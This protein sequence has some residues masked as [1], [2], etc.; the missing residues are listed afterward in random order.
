VSA[1]SPQ[2]TET[3]SLWMALTFMFDVAKWQNPFWPKYPSHPTT[4]LV[5]FEMLLVVEDH[6]YQPSSAVIGWLSIAL[7]WI[8]N[9]KLVVL[10]VCG[11][12]A[13]D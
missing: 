7:T 12:D 2:A 6:N 5:K 3:D 13:V 8:S 4:S 10:R 11:Q 1:S 9:S